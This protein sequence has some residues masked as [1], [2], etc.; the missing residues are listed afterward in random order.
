MCKWLKNS[1]QET[2]SEIV[3]KFL[4]ESKFVHWFLGSYKPRYTIIIIEPKTKA[5]RPNMRH[6]RGREAMVAVG[7]DAIDCHGRCT[8]S[9]GYRVSSN[10]WC[11]HVYC[12]QL[13]LM[14][15]LAIDVVS[16]SVNDVFE[17]RLMSRER[18]EDEATKAFLICCYND[19]ITVVLISCCC[20]CCN[21]EGWPHVQSASGSSV[22]HHLLQRTTSCGMCLSFC[23]LS[24]LYSSAVSLSMIARD[25]PGRLRTL[26]WS[27]DQWSS[28]SMIL[29]CSNNYISI[30]IDLKKSRD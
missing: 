28:S 20:C 19:L 22:Y 11:W 21:R 17:M 24:H 5:A 23:W 25:R 12:I 8:S 4:L 18:T 14:L 13:L 26:I 2:L 3:R 27:T 1:H 6:N 15:L 30:Q 7:I 9:I 10:R 29:H 16:Q